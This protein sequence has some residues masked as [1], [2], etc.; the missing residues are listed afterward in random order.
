[1]A[2]DFTWAHSLAFDSEAI[3]KFESAPA[4]HPFIIHLAE[5]VDKG[6]SQEIFA[7][8]NAGALDSRTVV[9][10]GL[11][12]ERD[13]LRLL[14]ESG[15]ALIWCPTS[16]C[17]LFGRTHTLE[18]ISQI[19][20]VILGND[21]P[22]TAA[23]DLLDEIHFAH[24]SIGVRAVEL[25]RQVTSRAAKILR[26]HGGQGHIRLGGVADLIA[27]RDV[28]IDPAQRLAELST[29]DIELVMLKGEIQL[30]SQEI[31]R[32]LPDYLSDGLSPILVEGHLVWVRAPLKRMF[33]D[34]YSA[35]GDEWKLGGKEVRYALSEEL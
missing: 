34:T 24:R 21:S 14:R 22:L 32:R 9:V 28:G 17:F 7:L 31:M 1:V 26:V 33:A 5:G 11:A 3:A 30:A 15:A 35:L 23:G 18:V 25:Y 12:L 19:E 6:S 2:K 10:H 16:N 13:G 20:N 8:A 4:D 29:G 27:V